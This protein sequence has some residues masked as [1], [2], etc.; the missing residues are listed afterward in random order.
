MRPLRA[1]L[2]TIIVAAFAGGCSQMPTSPAPPAVQSPVAAPEAVLSIRGGSVDPLIAVAGFTPL[3]FD[4]SRSTGAG[5]TYRIEFGDGASGGGAVVTRV[6]P[7]LFDAEMGRD[8]TA[9]LTVT[10]ALGRSA[11]TRQR[12]FVAG[13]QNRT[14]TFWFQVG[15]PQRKLTFIQEGPALT[16]WYRSDESGNEHFTGTLNGDGTV[17]LRTDDG[18][19]ELSGSLVWKPDPQTL[20]STYG[21]VLRVALKRSGAPAVPLDFGLGNPY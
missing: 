4:A 3:V 1:P 16:G 13:L 19:V 5:L 15:D 17:A 10:D 18:Q 21:L 8:F 2:A 20:F 11:S 6:P 12:Y 9:T 14:G 7:S